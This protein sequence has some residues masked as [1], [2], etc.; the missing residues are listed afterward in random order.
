MPLE[1]RKMQ[2]RM[3]Y[4]ISIKGHGE[5]HPVKKVLETCWEYEYSKVESY[6]WIPDKEAQG[7]GINEIDVSLTVVLATVPTWLYMLPVVDL[8]LKNII[9]ENFGVGSETIYR[10][11]V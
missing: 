2:L 6:G 1:F 7:M 8:Q 5:M 4:W 3:V 9:L 10:H 11:G